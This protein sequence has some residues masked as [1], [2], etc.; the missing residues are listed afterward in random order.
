[1]ISHL[2]VDH[3]C[4]RIL[5]Q[6]MKEFEDRSSD[7]VWHIPSKFSREM[8]TKSDVVST[9]YNNVTLSLGLVLFNLNCRYH[10]GFNSEM[11]T[12][13]KKWPMFW[14][15][16]MTNMFHLYHFTIVSLSLMAPPVHM[17][18]HNSITCLL[19]VISLL[20]LELEELL[21]CDCYTPTLYIVWIESLPLCKTGM[22]A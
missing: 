20:L 15:N 18:T 1:M 10:W 13:L 3:F 11:R 21:L 22:L 8:S 2:L 16:F 14:K 12:S 5:V 7:I 6:H 4:Y 17:T 19:A 9:C